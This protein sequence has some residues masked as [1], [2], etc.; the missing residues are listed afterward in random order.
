MA[1]VGRFIRLL[2]QN[3]YAKR[4]I[5]VELRRT[6][7]QF[8]SLHD[9]E[10]KWAIPSFVLAIHVYLVLKELKN[11]WIICCFMQTWRNQQIIR[12]CLTESTFRYTHG[13]GVIPHLSFKSFTCL[14]VSFKEY[15]PMR[16]AYYYCDLNYEWMG[17]SLPWILRRHINIWEWCSFNWEK[18]SDRWMPQRWPIFIVFFRCIDEHT[19]QIGKTLANFIIFD[20]IIRT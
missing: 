14:L 20:L 11:F 3:L 13:K 7:V 12:Y 16:N 1:F 2:V 4:F 15:V 8:I 10:V 5:W 18:K 6:T 19:Q 17:L 9:R